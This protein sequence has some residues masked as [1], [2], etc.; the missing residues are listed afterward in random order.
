MSVDPE[1]ALYVGDTTTDIVAG[2]AAD[3]PTVGVLSGIGSRE[4]LTNAGAKFVIERAD[5][6]VHIL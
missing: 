1:N 3:V 4:E 6:L 2:K 5:H